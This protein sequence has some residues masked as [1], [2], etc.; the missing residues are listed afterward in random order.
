MSSSSEPCG[1]ENDVRDVFFRGCGG[2]IFGFYVG[3]GEYW[4]VYSAKRF[5]QF[6]GYFVEVVTF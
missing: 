5:L 6:W 4:G 2:R 3:S 1:R